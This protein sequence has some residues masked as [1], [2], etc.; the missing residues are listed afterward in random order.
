MQVTRN[1][2]E[3][4]T[5]PS[6][7]F[8]GAVYVDSVTA[9]SGPSRLSASIVHFTP[10]ARTAWHMH[11]NGQTIY[12]T[13]GVGLAQRRGAPIEVIRPGDRVSFEPGE[14]HWHGTAPNRFMTHLA[15]QQVDDQG[16]AATW[17]DH[18]IDEE[19]GAAPKIEEA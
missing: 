10:G 4:M 17:G 6:D 3:A 19:Y 2:I 1:S 7:W 8:T 14:A 12:V 5:G 11:P 15:M 16:N 18:V 9:P 13:E